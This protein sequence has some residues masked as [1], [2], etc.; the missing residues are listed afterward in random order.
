VEIQVVEVN[1]LLADIDSVEC[2]AAPSLVPEEIEANFF[3][4]PPPHKAN[5]YLLYAEGDDEWM[6]PAQQI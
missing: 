2:D 6:N 3:L 4:P 1:V 5:R